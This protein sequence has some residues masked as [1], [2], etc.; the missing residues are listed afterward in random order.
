MYFLFHLK[1]IFF[2]FHIED[3]H[4]EKKQNFF[5]SETKNKIFLKWNKKINFFKVK[6]NLFHFNK[7]FIFVT[8]FILFIYDPFPFS[9]IQLNIFTICSFLLF[10]TNEVW[11]R[12]VLVL[13][14][15]LTP[16]KNVFSIRFEIPETQKI[17]F[18][19]TLMLVGVHPLSVVRRP[20]SA[21]IC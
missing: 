5:W 2:L 9:L 6:Q 7:I 4:A 11:K 8:S 14:K 10:R 18:Q 21:K 1:K 20:S 17:T 12:K 19:G 3:F 15:K 16:P 13:P